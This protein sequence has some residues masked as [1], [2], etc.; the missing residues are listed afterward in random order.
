MVRIIRIAGI[1]NQQWALFETMV[2]HFGL[3]IFLPGS[4][5]ISFF[6]S[7]QTQLAITTTAY[8]AAHL[9]NTISRRSRKLSGPPIA[10]NSRRRNRQSWTV[11][12]KHRAPTQGENCAGSRNFRRRKISLPVHVVAATTGRAETR[13]NR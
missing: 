1:A 8:Q 12:P 3:E 13:A 9:Y 6:G 5:K 4:K 7:A 10:W 11:E 2:P